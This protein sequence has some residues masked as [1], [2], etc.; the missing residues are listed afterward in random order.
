MRRRGFLQLSLST[1][2]ASAV[3]SS[4]RAAELPKLGELAHSKGLFFGTAVSDSQLHRPEFTPLVLDQCSILVAEN[5][6]KW[7]ATHPEQD[8]FDFTQADF[9]MD[10]AESHH[11][12]ARGHN[13]CWHE[14]N[15]PWLDS[16]IT[17]QNAVSLLTTHIQTVVAR[18][19][20]RIHSWDVLNEAIDPTHKNPQGLR[21]SLWLQNIGED[22]IELAYRIAAKADP[23]AILTYNDYDIETDATA[24]DAKREAILAMLQR[25]IKKGVPIRALGVQSHLRTNEG[26]P[27]W[28]GL[29]KFLL[30]IQKLNLQVFVTELDVDDSAMP[31]DIPE[32]DR[33]VAQ[34]YRSFLE[35]ILRHNSVRAVLTWCLSDRDSWLQNFRPRKDALPQRPLPFDAQ[36]NPKPSFYALHDSLAS[37]P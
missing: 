19:K 11:I 12:P 29:N 17:Q 27:T 15:P 25:L 30:E 20:G 18:Y 10:F 21:N 4:S 32:R 3:A 37:K 9:F 22:Y 34:L 28:N 7:R 31:A 8:R 23:A 26:T 33:Q 24:Q 1:L 14:H 35:N 5:Q 6:M 2:A 36:L 16:A 13:L